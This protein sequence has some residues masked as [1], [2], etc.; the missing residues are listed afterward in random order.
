[1]VTSATSEKNLLARIRSL[2]SERDTLIALLAHQQ[3][4]A[5]AGLVTSGLAHDVDNHVQVISGS[6]FLSLQRSNPAEWKQTLERIQQQCLELTE[7]TR[8]FLSFV[9]RR[10]ESEGIRFR[11][12]GTYASGLPT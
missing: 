7:T 2:E 4:V 12:Q 11:A 10:E 8:A 3:R 6:A 5:Q 1:M 9:R